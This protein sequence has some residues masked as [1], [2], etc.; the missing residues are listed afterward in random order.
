[1]DMNELKLAAGAPAL[2]GAINIMG[3]SLGGTQDA[4]SASGLSAQP[5]DNLQAILQQIAQLVVLLS[6]LAQAQAQSQNQGP[7][8]AHGAGG[9]L[10]PSL[11]SALQQLK[12]L[13]G[14][15]T[16]AQSPLGAQSSAAPLSAPASRA[17]LAPPASASGKPSVGPS[18]AT[19]N[20]PAQA[21]PMSRQQAV[22]VLTDN[23]AALE[24][25]G[26]IKLDDL[27]TIADGKSVRDL[28]PSA[29]LRQA[30]KAIMGDEDLAKS[31]DTQW[32]KDGR[33]SDGVIGKD[34]LLSALSESKTFAQGEREAL[35]TLDKYKGALISK[36]DLAKMDDLRKIADTGKM[37]DG[38]A[39]PADLQAAAARVTSS[40][41][42]QTA[43][44]T[45]DAA[46]QGKF[47][48]TQ[49]D[50]RWSAKDLESALHRDDR[51]TIKAAIRDA[52][53][54]AP[55]VQDVVKAA[56]ERFGDDAKEF[57][58][59]ASKSAQGEL[60]G[61]LADDPTITQVVQAAREATG[62]KEKA[63]VLLGAAAK[64]LGA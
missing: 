35:A 12:Q 55:A 6:K 38:S 62:T 20:T 21:A 60:Q 3:A 10:P 16:A 9:G 54:D 25:E 41:W 27:K 47:Q 61:K 36:D 30:A 18:S 45:G 26:G 44:D 28:K 63:A 31:L 32:Q 39:A 19:V 56:K 40:P 2:G 42:L 33:K 43:L 34:D 22:R 29:E 37:P 5:L 8:A 46:A 15:P 52:S 23:F 53:V 48:N 14:G 7:G 1:M 13:L 11:L 59:A 57:I 49:G 4:Q 58:A 51:A 64:A 50:D 24:N 17:P